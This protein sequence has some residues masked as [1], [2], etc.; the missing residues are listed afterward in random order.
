ML[1]IL[2]S[3]SGGKDSCYALMQTISSGHSIKT[4]LNM[5]NENGKISRSHA[6][7]LAVLQ[8]QAAALNI[9]IHTV[10]STWAD[11]EIN[12]I[13]ALQELKKKYNLDAAVFGDIDLQ[14]HRDW[15]EKICAATGIKALL[16]LWQ[17]C[18]KPLVMEMIAGSIGATIVSCNTK[19]GTEFLGKKIDRVLI[20]TLEKMG[21]DAC[22]EN[23]EY[24]TLVTNCPIFK[25]P[26]S[27]TFGNKTQYNNYCFIE[28][29]AA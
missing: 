2:S 19:M 9:P 10:A 29:I 25:K 12:F 4:L 1:N 13:T 27:V 24:H 5:M 23:G 21:I 6:I 26:V 14:P 28:I 7:P 20:K 17:Q 22:G 18:R 11:Y 16:P 8:K 15:E 3:W